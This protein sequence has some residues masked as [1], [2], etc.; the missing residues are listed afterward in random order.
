[1]A[2]GIKPISS[3]LVKP[4]GPDCN[5]ACEYCFYLGKSSLY[6]HETHHRMSAEVL[7]EMIK[8]CM[9]IFPGP[10]VLAWQG[11]E[12][13]IMGLDFFRQVVALQIKYG[14]SGQIVSNSLQTNGTLVDIE[15]AKFLRRYNFLVGISIDG[16]PEIHDKWRVDKNGRDSLK[17]V[18]CGLRALQEG[19]VDYNVLVMVTSESVGKAQVIWGFLREQGVNYFQFIPCLER[20]PATGEVEKFSVSAQ[21]YGEFMCQIFDLWASSGCLDTYVRF[22]ND[23]LEIYRGGEAHICLMKERCGDYVVV[24][25]NGDIY[26]CDFFVEPD[27]YV[28]NLMQEPLA[29]LVKDSKLEEFALMKS[30]TKGECGNCK[31]WK[32]CHGGCPKDRIFGVG[33]VNSPSYLCDSYK[34]IFEHADKRLQKMAADLDSRLGFSSTNLRD[35]P[36]S[37]SKVGLE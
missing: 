30:K 36:G 37:V 26:P 21:A 11:G 24:E 1:M 29:E 13:T 18:L 28:G 35:V 5:L 19:Q 23:L 9:N 6:Q 17:R 34:M 32:Q 7:E 10:A 12:P 2:E 16:P 3:V 4:A 31:W 8:Q 20:D 33:Q 14:R 15:W 22:F 27:Y 25:H